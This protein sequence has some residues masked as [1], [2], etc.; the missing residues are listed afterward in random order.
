MVAVIGVPDP[1]WGE[2]VK[3]FIVPPARCHTG[4]HRRLDRKRQTAKRS[5]LCPEVHRGRRPTT[6]TKVG[7][8]DKKVLRAT[9]W[10]GLDR[11]VN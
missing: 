6:L 11:A 7:K 10:A 4:G 5:A 1:K 8:I 3:A 9:Y 2:A